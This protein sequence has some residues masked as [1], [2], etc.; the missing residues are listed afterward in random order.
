MKRI[1]VPTDFSKTSLNAIDYAAGLCKELGAEMLLLNVMHVPA[2]DPSMA[3]N[4]LMEIEKKE[5]FKKLNDLAEKVILEHA[6]EVSVFSKFGL[7]S[8]VIVA[9]A[10]ESEAFLIVMG[11]NGASGMLDKMLGSVSNAVAKK[12][13]VPVLVLPGN[14]SYVTMNKVVFAYDY[15]EKISTEMEFVHELN[16]KN[17]VQIDVISVEP[18]EDKG[19]YSEEIILDEN[20]VKEV[21][22]WAS[23]VTIGISQYVKKEEVQ[24]VAVKRHHRNFIE[25]L[26]HK[27][28]TKELLNNGEIPLLVFN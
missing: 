7:G 24:L 16:A 12:S 6:M 27:S 13:E 23:S 19:L 14:S 10:E 20:G 3:M 5:S 9:E 2:I 22:I 4:G 17:N 26:F 11:T 28:T 1:L 21:S 15:K 25:E 8:D 18:D